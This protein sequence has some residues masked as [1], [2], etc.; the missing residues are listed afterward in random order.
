MSYL[1]DF[2]TNVF[3]LDEMADTYQYYHDLV[4]PYVLDE[5]QKFTQISSAQ[6]FNESVDGLVQYTQSRIEIAENYL[7]DQ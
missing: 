3:I 6:D 4:S 7:A 1:D 2:L 5:G